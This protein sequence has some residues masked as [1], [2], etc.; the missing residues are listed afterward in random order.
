VCAL[1]RSIVGG[2]ASA[3]PH[4][5]RPNGCGGMYTKSQFL[6]ALRARADDHRK[7]RF[8]PPTTGARAAASVGVKQPFP[9]NFGTASL[10]GKQAY[11]LTVRM[12]PQVTTAR[13][14]R[15]AERAFRAAMRRFGGKSRRYAALSGCQCRCQR[16]AAQGISC[17]D[18]MRRIAARRCLGM[19]RFAPVP[20]P[21]T[22]AAPDKRDTA[23]SPSPLCCPR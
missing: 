14:D 8:L 21:H 22:R 3:S 17:C 19:V 20:S 11:R 1:R 15:S 9:A 23:R 13:A 2:R 7:R 5:E 10:G 6:Q 12:L 4:P 18:A 16:N